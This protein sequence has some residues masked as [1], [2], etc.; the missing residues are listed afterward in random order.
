MPNGVHGI[1]TDTLDFDLNWIAMHEMTHIPD[2]MR[3]KRR[4]RMMYKYTTMQLDV[5]FCQYLCTY[6]RIDLPV[7]TTLSALSLALCEKLS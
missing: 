4:G 5:S 2:C 6:R 7:Q 1:G 3:T